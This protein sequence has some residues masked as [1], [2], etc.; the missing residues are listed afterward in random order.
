[1]KQLKR[2]GERQLIT[3]GKE[4]KREGKGRI[5][6]VLEIPSL[7]A[8]VY[9][10]NKRISTRAEKLELMLADPPEND[11]NPDVDI[12]IAWPIDLLVPK[13]NN[14][15]IV[16][17]LMPKIDR[18]IAID[19]YYKKES[20]NNQKL[21][22]VSSESFDFSCHNPYRAA[23][24][25]AAAFRAIHAKGYVIGDVNESNILV[26]ENGSIVI[27]NT[28]SFQ[29]C[30]LAKNAIYYCSTSNPEFTPPELQGKNLTKVHRTPQQD[31]FGLGILIFKLLMAGIHPYDSIFL[32]TEEATTLVKPIRLGHFPYGKRKIPL[33]P[34][35]ETPPF[36]HL[37]PGLQ[38]LF[39]TCFETGHSHP[40]AR[41]NGI[42]WQKTLEKAQQQ[43]LTCEKN[44][45]HQ[46]GN[47][48]NHC[49]W[50]DTS[51][52]L[53]LNEIFPKDLPTA[54]R[55]LSTPVH[56]NKNPST[57]SYQKPISK[58]PTKAKSSSSSP[59]FFDKN[60]INAP[61]KSSKSSWLTPRKKIT[62][63]GVSLVGLLALWIFIAI[64][65]SYPVQSLIGSI[66]I[67]CLIWIIFISKYRK[68]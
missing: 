25:L 27:V 50:C 45:Q 63:W 4:L 43:L 18:A 37:H 32:S 20:L 1:M 67:G 24:N 57:Y 38:E 54:D 59:A 60:K 49:P 5:Y 55:S 11:F 51:L 64:T 44:R 28:D 17:Y 2:L 12:A 35:P 40:L 42:A 66:I 31:L 6:Q 61:G 22:D 14:Q 36:K 3:L 23:I 33:Y 10:P 58:L 34:P 68:K 56:L 16:G 30:N 41:P 26:K 8:K 19:R 39:I 13:N 53:D 7:V 47:H 29:V 46:Y 9:H 21:R 65:I 15:A 52:E 62:I 48:L